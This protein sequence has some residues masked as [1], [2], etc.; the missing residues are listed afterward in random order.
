MRIVHVAE[1]LSPAN[2]GI[3]TSVRE[4]A[5]ACIAGGFEVEAVTVGEEVDLGVPGLSLRS[6]HLGR[7]GSG[8]RYA[9]AFTDKL[10]M[11]VGDGAVIHVHGMWMYPQWRAVHMA[12]ER[13]WP[14]VVS[15]HNMLGGWLWRCGQVR[16]LK[17]RIYFDAMV[18]KSF[19]K[20]RAIH[21]LSRIEHD[22][23]AKN[24]FPGSRVITIPN[25]LNLPVLD[26]QMA[27]AKGPRNERYALFI[28]RLHPVKGLDLL[29]DAVACMP[30]SA[31]I[32]VVIA[33]PASSN[34]YERKL[35]ERVA[36]LGLT[37]NVAFVGPVYGYEKWRLLR[38]AWVFCAPS[39]SEGMSMAALEAMAAGVPVITTNGSGLSNIAEGGG[40][41]VATISEDIGLALEAA[42]AWDYSERSNRSRSARALVEQHYSWTTVWPQYEELYRSL[43]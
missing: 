26:S 11:A 9:P 36:R 17:K 39:H 28:G 3:T 21:A 16:Q 41:L 4:F 42:F 32:K 13:N 25:A 2:T 10:R 22:E 5:Q 34:D 18:S 33:G 40:L 14:L 12:I 27:T 19:G 30:H 31:E 23:L 20:A 24:Y 8:W 1:D 35:K 38:G 6:A 37:R 43:L 7:I 15:P 29:I